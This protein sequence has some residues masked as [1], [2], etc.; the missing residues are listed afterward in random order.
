[1]DSEIMYVVCIEACA[2]IGGCGSLKD[3]RS[4]VRGALAELRR[5]FSASVAEVGRQ[6][7]LDTLCIGVA[8]ACS[9]MGVARHTAQ[10]VEEWFYSHGEFIN[11]DVQTSIV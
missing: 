5:R 9:D 8:V 3:K 1:M 7:S 10:A 6:N 4:I 2:H 11:A